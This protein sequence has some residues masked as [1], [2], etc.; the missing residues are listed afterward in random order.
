MHQC[1]HCLTIYDE[2]AGEEENG[3]EAGTVFDMLP[4]SYAC[5]L[6]G[7]PKEDFVKVEKGKLGLLS[8]PAGQGSI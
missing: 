6:C 7:S 5:S 2:A 4:G 1:K 8:L 3:I